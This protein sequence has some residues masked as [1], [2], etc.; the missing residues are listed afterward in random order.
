M[1]EGNFCYKTKSCFLIPEL[2]RNWRQYLKFALFDFLNL[3]VVNELP[4][5][6]QCGLV[7]WVDDEW[8]GLLHVVSKAHLSQF[9]C[10]THTHAHIHTLIESALFLSIF[11]IKFPIIQIHIYIYAVY[12][13]VNI[14]RKKQLSGL[15]GTIFIWNEARE[16]PLT[17]EHVN[18]DTLTNDYT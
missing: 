18:K 14:D 4:E 16:N 5:L 6:L 11:L 8:T 12:I 2:L 17:M 10:H 3:E 13:C 9:L 1:Q 15:F 7:Y